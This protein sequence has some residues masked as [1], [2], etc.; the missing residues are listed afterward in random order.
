MKTS[1]D[2][3]N[4]K[5][6]ECN[7]DSP[8]RGET[9]SGS[10]HASRR[11][12]L[13]SSTAG[14]VAGAL[15]S[16]AALPGSLA[17]Q[18]EAALAGSGAN[19]RRVLLQ[20]GIVLSMDPQVGDFERADV[21]IEGAKIAAVGPNLSASGA[22]VIDAANRIVLPGFIDTHHHQYQ[23]VLRGIISD[24]LLAAD[25]N[26][27]ITS[28]D[29]LTSFFQPEDA[30]AGVLLAS[31]SQ[32]RAGVTTAIDLSQVQNSP[33][34]TD[35]CIAGFRESGRRTVVAYSRGYG[36]ATRY[37]QDITRLRSQYFSSE[38]QL[39]T[40]FLNAGVEASY[41]ELTR[42]TGVPI[43]AHVT[44]PTAV[45]NLEAL[46]RA[47]LMRSDNTYIHCIRFTE[48]TWQMVRDTGGRISISPIIEMV[49]GH[50]VPPFQE[51]LDHDIRPSFSSD[52]ETVLAADMFTMMRSAFQDARRLCAPELPELPPHQN[53]RRHRRQ[54]GVVRR[55]HAVP[56]S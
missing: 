31:V 13:K 49:M 44:N 25:Y 22:A 38:D 21:L 52:V 55:C 41:W 3:P 39:L 2:T 50:G 42:Q 33:A 1:A 20:G 10:N 43:I 17:A 51:A 18:N 19:G 54:F 53:H 26:R 56:S 47:G 8:D 23:S 37:P 11:R 29:G 7:P 28:P 6:R 16:G 46:G 15:A 32:I 27:L 5:R 9:L 30:Y 35:A 4:S 34:H 40:L 12:F 14:L 45:A 36:A 24:G 48:T